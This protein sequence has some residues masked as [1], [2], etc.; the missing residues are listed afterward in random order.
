MYKVHLS[1][2]PDAK[3]IIHLNAVQSLRL[4]AEVLAGVGNKKARYLKHLDKAFGEKHP[5]LLRDLA[6]IHLLGLQKGDVTLISHPKLQ[7][8]H[9]AVIRDWI[10]TNETFLD[11]VLIYLFPGQDIPKKEGAVAEAHPGI[12]VTD[13]PVRQ[14]T[15]DDV[16]QIKALMAEEE[17]KE[18]LIPPKD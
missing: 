15:E 9:G 8:L 14:L 2:K 5:Q 18:E 11:S 17:E 10:K 13:A 4:P 12:P 3:V 16:R 6:N 7:D 1:M